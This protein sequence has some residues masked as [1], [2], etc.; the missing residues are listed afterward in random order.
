MA[1]SRNLRNILS[2]YPNLY[3]LLRKIRFKIWK[4]KIFF[5]TRFK[6]TQS[7]TDRI[8][9]VDPNRI[10]EIGVGWGNY[11]KTNEIG[12]IVGGNWDL[13]TMSFN[14]L[15]IHKAFT[16]RFV[17]GKEWEETSYYQ[18]LIYQIESG[19]S[20]PSGVKDNEDISRKLNE[21]DKLFEN[22]KKDG[23]KTK[24]ELEGNKPA[25]G[26]MDEITVRIGRA[27]EL[28]FE[29]GRHRLSISKI[30]GIKEVPIRVTWRHKDWYLFR[31]QILA[32]AKLSG[33]GKLYQPITHPDLSD[34][35]SDHD[36]TRYKLINS[37]MDFKTG[38]LLDIGAYW[39]YFCHKFEDEGFQCYAVE[40][41]ARDFYFL[42]R[43]RLIEKRKFTAINAD[44]F[45]FIEKSE[46]DVILALNVF[47]HFL[48]T[49]DNYKKLV[50]YLQIIKTKVMFFE[51][52]LPNEAQMENAYQNFDNKQFVDFIIENTRLT[53]SE[54]IGHVN[55]G[56]PIYKL[57][58]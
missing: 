40:K 47:H 34:I 30:L 58:E 8:L 55:D 38:T 49:S 24:I 26:I 42:D 50:K 11:N 18:N 45:D 43:I 52:H 16:G 46:F 23:Y 15:D 21:M 13:N 39:G 3:K 28:L 44:I 7:K 33:T 19:K 2:K 37:K 9:M 20:R 35:P 57:T 25:I 56:R 17:H 5:R 41:S 12:K 53:K 29:D 14:D 22:I 6:S 51:P 48:K 32:H 31:L 36:E 54:C 27:G 10:E 1:L 4:N